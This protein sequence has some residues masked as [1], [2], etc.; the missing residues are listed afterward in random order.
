MEIAANWHDGQWSILYSFASTGELTHYKLES[1]LR[2]IDICQPRTMNDN[3][4]LLKLRRYVTVHFQKP[5]Y[6]VYVTNTNNP[7]KDNKD[8]VATVKHKGDVIIITDALNK[9]LVDTP[10]VYFWDTE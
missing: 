2:D 8:L 7:D 6:K 5:V 4:E 1:Y 9:N 10:L 3:R